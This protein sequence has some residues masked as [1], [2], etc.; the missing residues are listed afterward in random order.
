MGTLIPNLLIEC[1]PDDSFRLS[2]QTLA[3]AAPMISPIM[4]DI[5]IIQHYFFVPNRIVY[6]DQDDWHDFISQDLSSDMP[7]S[8]AYYNI[9]GDNHT[10]ER[11]SVLNYLGLPSNEPIGESAGQLVTY[12]DNMAVSAIPLAAYVKVCNEYYRDEN[13]QEEVMATQNTSEGISAGLNAVPLWSMERA[14]ILRKAWRKDYFTSALPFEQ[15]GPVVSL[16]MSGDAQVYFNNTPDGTTFGWD[17]INTSN[18]SE[19]VQLGVETKATADI[20]VGELYADLTNISSSTINDL[21]TAIRLQEWFELA[22]RAGTRYV[23]QL[24]AHFDVTPD[25]ARLQ[26]PNFIGG[27]RSPLIISEVLQTSET[28]TENTPLGD[29]AGHGIAVNNA[30]NFRYYCKEHGYIIGIFSILPKKA[31][32]QGIQRHW[33]R[34]EWTDYAW[35]TFA[36]LGEQAVLNQELYVSDD[37]GVNKGTFGYQSRYAEYKYQPSI[38]VGEFTGSLDYWHLADKYSNTPT[39]S[40]EFIEARPRK[41]IFAVL[42][43]QDFYC[44]TYH[45]ISVKRKLPKFGVPKL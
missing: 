33:F 30:R 11:S 37:D 14:S 7:S 35:P 16:P 42:D 4:H 12:P 28:N 24:L 32:M 38:A 2:S 18:P 40:A 19:Q 31:Y 44:H 1:L 39:L 25:D 34:Q 10:I 22:A 3:R 5:S 21:R 43:E 20:P 23:E 6:A 8:W 41:D 29:Y 13:L 26:R 9:E 15:K 17:A 45:Q 36:A 27:S